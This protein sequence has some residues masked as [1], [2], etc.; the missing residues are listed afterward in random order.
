MT[1]PLPFAGAARPLAPADIAQAARDLGCDRAAIEAVLAV[2]TGGL[3]GF[4]T[5]GSG[6]PAILFEAHHF[7]RESGG[8]FD[9]SHPTLSVRSWDRSLYLGG[10]AEYGRLQAAVALDRAAALRATSWGLF[11]ILGSNHRAAGF[12]SAEA[13]VAAMAESEGRHLGA[14]IGFC[15]A[16]GPARH[17]VVLDWASFARGYNGGAYRENRYDTRL[18]AAYARARAAAPPEPVLRI[19][20]RGEAVQALQAALNRAGARLVVDGLFGRAT[21]LALEAFQAVRRLGVDGVAGPATR[22]ALLDS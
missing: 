11:Q 3:G 10:R 15:R 12:A 19:G 17:L 1:T 14:F 13:F 16:N 21:E 6:R 2:E 18:A 20:A 22:A 7:S 5:D 8:R 9:A 4:L